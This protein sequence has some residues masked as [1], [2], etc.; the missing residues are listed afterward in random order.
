M[1]HST[2]LD[3]PTFS[4]HVVPTMRKSQDHLGVP[5]Q[6]NNTNGHRKI[7]SYGNKTQSFHTSF[8]LVIACATCQPYNQMI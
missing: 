6:G 2:F 5:S 1:M 3:M 4:V 7:D 8:L